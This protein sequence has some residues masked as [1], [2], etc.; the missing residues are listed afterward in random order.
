MRKIMK[1]QDITLLLKEVSER[2]DKTIGSGDFYSVLE[3][4]IKG[5]EEIV[6]SAIIASL[7]DTKGTHGQGDYFLNKFLEQVDCF[8]NESSEFSTDRFKKFKTTSAR[9]TCEK[10]IGKRTMES[11][12]RLDICIESSNGQTI[13]IENKIFAGDQEHQICRYV[14]Y[15][16]GRGKDRFPVL[17]L[18]PDGHSPSEISTCGEE[19]IECRRN[20]DY[21][22]ISYREVI[23]PWLEKSIEKLNNK[24]HLKDHIETYKNIINKRVLN[25][26]RNDNIIR[27][28]ESNSRNIKAAREIS[29]QLNEIEKDAITNLW[30]RIYKKLLELIRDEPELKCFQPDYCHFEEWNLL[31]PKQNIQNLVSNYVNN[32][33]EN[34]R[35][36]GIC[37]P[38]SNVD[39]CL[40]VEENLYFAIYQ[41]NGAKKMDLPVLKKDD[42]WYKEDLSRFIAWKYPGPDSEKINLKT[43]DDVVWSLACQKRKDKEVRDLI[44]RLSSEFI[45]IV[46]QI[47]NSAQHE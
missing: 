35:Y 14:E 8:F 31:K 10:G 40:I 37:I 12:G 30:K 28:I 19:N 43:P 23:V 6:H 38:L 47:S 15:L 27:T 5:N 21:A 20:E 13:I 44:S 4:A 22:C 29:N 36:F 33:N 2:I 41:R 46:K 39:V 3:S 32:P 25:M 1:F 11:G 45:D 7:L 9:V 42:G 34:N 16:K 26:E 17:Y 18:T 24:T